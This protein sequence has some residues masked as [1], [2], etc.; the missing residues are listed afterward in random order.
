VASEIMTQT[1]ADSCDIVVGVL[2]KSEHTINQTFF[3]VHMHPTQVQFHFSR[4][5]SSS[6]AQLSSYDV[7]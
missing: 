7:V 6:L 1:P 5:L 4:T 3:P 2:A